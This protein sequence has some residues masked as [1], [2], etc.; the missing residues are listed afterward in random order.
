MARFAIVLVAVVVGSMILAGGLPDAID[1]VDDAVVTIYAGEDRM[2]AG[3]IVSPDGN[4]VTNSHVVGDDQTVRVKLA[5]NSE[6]EGRVVVR[7]KKRDLAVVKVP[8]SNLPIVQFGSSTAL[9]KGEE[10]AALG[11]P[12]GL[13]HSVTRGVVSNPRQEQDGKTYIQTDAALNPGNSGGPLINDQGLVV[14]MNAKVAVKA[15]NVGFA[16]PAEDVSAFLDE[17]SIPHSVAFTPAGETEQEGEEPEAGETESG[18]DLSPPK[19][20]VPEKPS[21]EKDSSKTAEPPPLP[22]GTPPG[23]A[24]GP[25]LLTV[26][27]VSAV[28]S[29]VV[30]LLSG[31]LAARM[32]VQ[33]ITA[34]TV[35]PGGGTAAAGGTGP[36]GGEQPPEDDLSDVDIELY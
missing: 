9:R 18:E 12:L 20:P 10:V 14:G 35:G 8:R 4:I 36:S 25:S 30:G 13:E 2:G 1:R 29:L 5:D 31:V 23:P 26:V 21:S 34:R 27:L 7:S 19:E 17:N 15:Q 6:V 22:P 33:K 28:I 3:F 11:A 16:I 24:R 32:T